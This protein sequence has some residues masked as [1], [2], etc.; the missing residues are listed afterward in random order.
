MRSRFIRTIQ[1]RNN[2]TSGAEWSH[3]PKIMIPSTMHVE[4]AVSTVQYGTVPY[5]RRVCTTTLIR[6]SS[7]HFATTCCL[8]L[9]SRYLFLEW[10]LGDGSLS[11]FISAYRRRNCRRRF[12]NLTIELLVFACSMWVYECSWKICRW[13]CHWEIQWR[14]WTRISVISWKSSEIRSLLLSIHYSEWHIVRLPRMKHGLPHT[15]R[16]QTSVVLDRRE[17]DRGAVERNLRLGATSI[18]IEYVGR[19]DSLVSLRL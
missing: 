10:L 8:G 17:S 6:I 18:R 3:N 13:R 11:C 5:R 9:G 15:E 19:T 2:I 1:I 16:N 4:I 14:R 7:P 12:T